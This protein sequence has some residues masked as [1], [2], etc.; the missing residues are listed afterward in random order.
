MLTPLTPMNPTSPRSSQ[1]DND[2]GP[3]SLELLL[4]RD[5]E[6]WRAAWTAIEKAKGLRTST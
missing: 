1:R 4:R 3:S 5:L 6:A 2:A